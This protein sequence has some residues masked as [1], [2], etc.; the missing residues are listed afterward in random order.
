VGVSDE[1]GVRPIHLAAESGSLDILAWLSESGADLSACDDLGRS[2]VW[3]AGHA[4]QLDAVKWLFKRGKQ[5]LGSLRCAPDILVA[6]LEYLLS[7]PAR[8]GSG[9]ARGIEE[10]CVVCL[11]RPANTAL[12]EC[13][14]VCTC[15]KCAKQLDEC[16]LCRQKLTRLLQLY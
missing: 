8:R 2:V 14:H 16:P 11:E 7:A 5:D 9:G 1:H 3:H 13:G 4:Q 6:L 12:A 15:F 10:E